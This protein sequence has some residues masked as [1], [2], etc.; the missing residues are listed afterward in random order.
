[1]EAWT[2]QSKANHPFDE[3]RERE[4]VL[5]LCLLAAIH[6]FIFSAAFPFFNNVDELA[7]FDL[8]VKYSH[9]QVPRGMETFSPD[10]SAYLAIF[11]SGEYWTD[12]KTLPDGKFPLP[13]WKQPAD[14]MRADM[15]NYMAVWQSRN[16]YEVSLPPL[17]Y[18]MAGSWWDMG[19][20]LGFTGGHLL[21]WLRFLNIALVAVMV[22]LGY[23]ATRMIFPDN[24]FLRLGVPGLLAFMPQTT[25]Y[26]AGNDVLSPL[27]FGVVFICLIKWLRDENPSAW[28]G[29]A[30]GIAF[31]AT[32]L[33][34]T[35]NLPLLAV[36]LAALMYKAWKGFN[37]SGKSR[38]GPTALGAFGC[39]ATP[40]IVCW[41]LWCKIHFGDLTGSKLKT[42]YFGWT[43]KPSGE[44]LHHPIFSLHGIWTYLSGQL[45]TFWQGEFT[46]HTQPMAP[47]V[48]NAIYT[49]LS[50]V[51]VGVTVAKLFSS[52][53]NAIQRKSLWLSL[54]SIAAALGFFA[55]LS[56]VYDFHNCPNPSREHPYFS[57]GRL[58]LGGLIPFLLLFVYGIDGA[59]NRFGTRI[60]FLALAA[61]ITFML[62]S[63]IAADTPVFSSQY[64]WFHL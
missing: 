21:Y 2:G 15:A 60:K 56:V 27:C 64:N 58:L 32:Y 42:D 37:A 51:L 8:I 16:N 53:L 11:T 7:H 59:L 63:E 39:G 13:L 61:M 40:P 17:Y 29:F 47:P 54:A 28:L 46:W 18:A 20:W 34:K 45:A 33:A 36:A 43:V 9:G 52:S 44:W 35:T 6:V 22:W 12:P 41:T 25:L 49:V 48:I 1:M 26:S 55:L 62:I 38:A 24:V 23:V 31:A 30:T 4:A 3:F 19:Q 10:S 5:L 50:L 14:K 57:S